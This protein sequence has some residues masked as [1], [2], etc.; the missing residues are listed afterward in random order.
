MNFAEEI[1]KSTMRVSVLRENSSTKSKEK[2]NTQNIF[3][4]ESY[5]SPSR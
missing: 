5:F 2:V 1:R 4:R 3:C